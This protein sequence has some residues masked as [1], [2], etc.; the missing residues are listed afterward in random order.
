M[1]NEVLV[2]R[3]IKGDEHAFY[4]LVSEQKEQL[5]RI[6]YSYLKNQG[7]ALEAIQEVTYR[8]YKAIGKL[9][10]PKYFHTWLI[11]I[12]MNYCR[13]ELRKQKRY[14]SQADYVLELA[15]HEDSYERLEIEEAV[16][17]LDER[18]Q[19][20]IK[21]KYFLDY[22]I[23]DIAEVMECPEGTVKTWLH[24]A[25]QSLRNQLQVKGGS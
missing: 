23:K 13:D 24:K 4:S 21:M 19:Q 1:S 15:I 12:M 8:A 20:V 25:L 14:S 11:R 2:I 7:D 17:A 5:Y 16:D 18:S 9:K 3:A 6:A 10:E 22:K